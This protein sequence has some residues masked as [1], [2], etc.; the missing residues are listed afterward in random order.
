M[1]LVD[2]KFEHAQEM[3]AHESPQTTKLYDHKTERLSQDEVEK[4]WL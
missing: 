1:R 4:I 2:A 3:A